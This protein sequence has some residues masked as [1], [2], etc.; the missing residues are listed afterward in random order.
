M[1]H[2]DVGRLF[3]SLVLTLASVK[4]QSTE[5]VRGSEVTRQSEVKLIQAS[6]RGIKAKRDLNFI[7]KLSD[8]T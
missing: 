6:E 1:E 7:L 4:D 8:F 3:R 2:F 5:Q